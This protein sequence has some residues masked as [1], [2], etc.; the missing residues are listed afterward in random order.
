[1]KPHKTERLSYQLHFL[2]FFIYSI[3]L[4]YS[5]QK[6]IRVMKMLHATFSAGMTSE[7]FFLISLVRS[8]DNTKMTCAVLIAAAIEIFVGVDCIY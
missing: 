8:E 4:G 1:M 3:H 2:L 6:P 7:I 5:V